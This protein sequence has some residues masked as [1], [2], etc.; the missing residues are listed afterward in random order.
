MVAITKH[1]EVCITGMIQKKTEPNDTENKGF[2]PGFLG[3]K[4]FKT[5]DFISRK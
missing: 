5:R 3:Q 1:F 4:S 2:E